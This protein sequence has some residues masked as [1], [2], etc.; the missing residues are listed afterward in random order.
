MIAPTADDEVSPAKKWMAVGTAAGPCPPRVPGQAPGTVPTAAADA[1]P[2]V[3]VKFHH[4]PLVGF[5]KLFR[6]TALSG[7]GR[8]YH[9]FA[10]ISLKNV[11]PVSSL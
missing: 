8:G 6:Q 2:V 10:L 3:V 5:P 1:F 9:P 11:E 4:R 7:P